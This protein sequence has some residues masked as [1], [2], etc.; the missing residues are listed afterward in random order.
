MR[1]ALLFALLF[2]SHAAHA[3]YSEDL[4]IT[5]VAFDV[6]APAPGGIAWGKISLKNPGHETLRNLVLQFEPG[7]CLT[8]VQPEV[9]VETLA[10]GQT[11]NVP[12]SFLFT[13]AANCRSGEAASFLLVGAFVN[14]AGVRER[15]WASGRFNLGAN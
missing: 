14:A 1:F 5:S 10:P 3:L 6:A 7:R 2:S 8:S 13:A 4:L 11:I 9:R 15:A 12:E